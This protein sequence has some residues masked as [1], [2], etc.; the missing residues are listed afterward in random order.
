MT[1][2]EAFHNRGLLVPETQRPVY[3]I[4]YGRSRYDKNTVEFQTN[5]WRTAKDELQQKWSEYAAARHIPENAV[6]EIHCIAS[7]DWKRKDT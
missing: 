7:G 1:I 3:R 4:T 2:C 5:D 6:L